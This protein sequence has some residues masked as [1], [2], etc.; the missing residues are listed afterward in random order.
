MPDRRLSASARN[1]GL[2]LGLGDLQ[3]TLVC[4]GYQHACECGECRERAAQT[5]PRFGAWLASETGWEV[6]PLVEPKQRPRQ[7]W[8]AVRRAA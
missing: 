7:P 3:H 1:L 6:P 8:E 5:S 2:I 4:H